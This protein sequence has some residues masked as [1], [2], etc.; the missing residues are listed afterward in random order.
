MKRMKFEVDVELVSGVSEI[1]ECTH[2]NSTSIGSGTCGVENLIIFS[3][4]WKG[5][6]RRYVARD[7]VGMQ[8]KCIGES[9]E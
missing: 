8:V 6:E 4:C 7:I 5:H 3:D 1:F 2:M 9:V